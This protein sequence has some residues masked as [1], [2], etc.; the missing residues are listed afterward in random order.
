MLRC[1]S[2]VQLC[3]ALRT[4]ACQAPLSMRFSRQ[5]YWSGLPYS[6]SR[7]LPNPG[8]ESV[9][10][11]FTDGFFASM[12][13]GKCFQKRYWKHRQKL[14]SER[15][16]SSSFIILKGPCVSPAPQVSNTP[17]CSQTEPSHWFYNSSEYIS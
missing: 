4:V 6:S 9:S 14:K 15:P 16:I 1:F 8:I 10:L 2:C 11:A 13:H 3:P 5:E 7:D 17:S 12:L